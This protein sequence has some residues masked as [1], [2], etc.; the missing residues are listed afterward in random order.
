MA[1][2]K[3]SFIL[4]SDN[5]GLIKQLPDDVAGRLLKHIFA[6]VNDENPISDDLLLNIAF[7]GIKMQLKRDLKKY[8][9]SKEEKSNGGKMGNLKRWNPD[10]YQKVLK[11]EMSLIDAEII[12]LSR[13]ASHTDDM[14]SHTI[15]SVAVNVNDNVS[16]NV[17]DNVSVNDILLE[18][19][20]K[21]NISAFNFKKALIDY[22]FKKEL[23][24]D[25]LKVRKTK[26]ATNT[27]TAFKSFIKEIE[28]R[29]CDINEML[30]IAVTNSWSGFKFKWVEN[31]KTTNNA[32]PKSNTEIFEQSVS[33]EAARSFNYSSLNSQR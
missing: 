31:L 26:K 23:V 11:K 29:S 32:G 20:S 12:A 6:Y 14:R 2:D 5:Y 10:L 8:E 28:S 19:E 33:G 13:K 24:E 17:N 4:Y 18:K 30:Q 27:E 3:K 16:V 1:A 25:W 7:E 9:T 21:N 15:A 22:G